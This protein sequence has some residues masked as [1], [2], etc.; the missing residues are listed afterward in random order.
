MADKIDPPVF[1]AKKF[2][3]GKP[4]LSLIPREAI[5]EMARGFSYGA[6]KYGRHNFEKGH[7]Y[8]RCLDA[9]LRHLFA[10]QAGEFIDAE[11]GN[12]HLAHAMCSLAILAYHVAHHPELNDLDRKA[13]ALKEQG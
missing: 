7:L 9:A 4:Q 5:E 1:G 10:I 3:T 13:E 12:T 11:S 8:S 2:D 6:T